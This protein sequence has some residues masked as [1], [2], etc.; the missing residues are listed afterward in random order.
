[1]N[2]KTVV[3]FGKRYAEKQTEEKSSGFQPIPPTDYRFTYRIGGD[4]TATHTARG[5]VKLNGPFI[6]LVDEDKET[7]LMQDARFMLMFEHLIS[8][9]RLDGPQAA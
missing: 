3:E 6:V 9:E 7:S 8:I 5:V 1:M 2:D 4:L